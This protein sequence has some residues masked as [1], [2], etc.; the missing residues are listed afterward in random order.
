MEETHCCFSSFS[1]SSLSSSSWFCRRNPELLIPRTD[2]SIGMDDVTEIDKCMCKPLKFTKKCRT[3]GWQWGGSNPIVWI[4]WYRPCVT[5]ANFL[6]PYLW[7]HFHSSFSLIK[8]GKRIQK[9]ITSVE[10]HCFKFIWK[11]GL[12]YR[13]SGFSLLV[14]LF[15]YSP[16]VLGLLHDFQSQWTIDIL[17]LPARKIKEV[18]PESNSLRA[19]VSN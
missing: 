15:Y 3:P 19:V 1:C 14:M 13:E 9:K 16:N 17:L 7:A 4:L 12:S 8:P 2:V 6:L 11:A 10:I 5:E 18:K